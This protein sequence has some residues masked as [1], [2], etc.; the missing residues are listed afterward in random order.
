MVP[1]KSSHPFVN[2]FF[3]PFRY[4]L[5]LHVGWAEMLREACWE[6]GAEGRVSDHGA[7]R[8]PVEGEEE[9]PGWKR[10]RRSQVRTAPPWGRGEPARRLLHGGSRTAAARPPRA[11]PTRSS[12][13]QIHGG[14]EGRLTGL[15]PAAQPP[16]GGAE[17]PGLLQAASRHLLC[18]GFCYLSLWPCPAA[19]RLLVPQSEV[20]PRPLQWAVGT[21]TPS[22]RAC[23]ELSLLFTK[24]EISRTPFLIY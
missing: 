2:G 18:S 7:G 1:S 11:G 16:G 8:A 20:N 22:Q 15:Q 14:S 5:R 24:Y 23:R 19:S 12:V 9:G 10:P 3:S 6:R 13:S 21:R 4:Q 17:Q